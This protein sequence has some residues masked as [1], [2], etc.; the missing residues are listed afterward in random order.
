MKNSAFVLFLCAFGGPTLN[1]RVTIATRK[2]LST[3]C[4]FKILA[5]T[6]LQKFTQNFKVM[7][8]AVLEF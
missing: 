4:K 2:G 3:I 6:Y 1:K 5:K 7:A 8:F